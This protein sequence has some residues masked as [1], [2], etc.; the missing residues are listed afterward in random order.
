MA[1][2]AIAM[3]TGIRVASLEDPIRSISSFAQFAAQVEGLVET[4]SDYHCQLLVFPEYFTAAPHPG[5]PPPTHPR[6]GPGPSRTS[7]RPMSS[8][9]ARWLAGGESTWWAA[10][11]PSG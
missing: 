10:L 6:A 11:S 1:D 8:S 5:R 9:L 2:P 4:A 7:A 3:E